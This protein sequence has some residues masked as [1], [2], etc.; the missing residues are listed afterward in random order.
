M[1]MEHSRP[2]SLGRASSTY[3]F[4]PGALGRR[5]CEN[6][7]VG[8]SSGARGASRRPALPTTSRSPSQKLE[9]MSRRRHA[10]VSKPSP[11]PLW[12][13]GARAT[14]PQLAHRTPS[15]VLARPNAP[16]ER[17]GVR[18]RMTPWQEGVSTEPATRLVPG[19]CFIFERGALQHPRAPTKRQLPRCVSGGR[20]CPR[21]EAQ[22]VTGCAPWGPSRRPERAQKNDRIELQTLL[23]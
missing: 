17:P 12:T 9:P 21:L 19:P 15:S 7:P 1:G 23:G 18:D 20:R 22:G 4:P 13:P 16:T 6:H 5:W 2:A 14:Y 11:C 10:A 3:A 8:A